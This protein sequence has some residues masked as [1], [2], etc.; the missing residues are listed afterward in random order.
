[1]NV[2]IALTIIYTFFAIFGI[3]F[4]VGQQYKFCR[5]TEAPIDDGVNPVFWPID[6]NASFLC[7]SDDMCSGFPNNLREGDVNA[8]AKCGDVYSDYGLDPETVDGTTDLE[9]IQFDIVNFNHLGTAI[10]TVFQVV[11]L[12]GWSQLMYN[13]MDTVS[14]AL[15]TIYFNI[16][17]LIGSFVA[18]NL[19]L[20]SIME[21]FLDEED[22]NV[23]DKMQEAQKEKRKRIGHSF[24]SS[25][26]KGEDETPGASDSQILIQGSQNNV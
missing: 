20:A 1:M 8:V 6:E 21:A 24:L 13:Y 22:T 10:I 2:L 25:T 17:V 26:E 4:F 14:V 9:I 11:T 3:N 16:V 19:V 18:L 12:E 15:S 7:S 5:M 23:Q